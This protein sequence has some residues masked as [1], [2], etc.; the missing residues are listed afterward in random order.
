MGSE[1]TETLIELQQTQTKLIQTEKM[2][3]LGQ[4]VGG[5]SHE[6]NNPISFIYGNTE[7]AKE[8]ARDLLELVKL[9]QQHYPQPDTEIE[10]YIEEI[11]LDFLAADFLKILSSMKT[12]AERIRKIIESLRNFSR[13]DESEIKLVNI[14]EG[15]ENTL[16]IFN[17]RMNKIQLKK[18][19]G[20][21]SL[22]EC[23]PAHI[24]QV[25]LNIMTNAI[26][27]LN[28][29]LCEFQD[30]KLDFKPTLKIDTEQI[31]TNQIKISFWNNGP[32]IPPQ[33]IGKLF[34]PFFTTKT[35]GKGTGLGLTSCYQIMQ[36]HG[37][38]IEVTSNAEYGTEFAVILPVKMPK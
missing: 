7:Y 15:I 5:I 17:H 18:N 27:A 1:L 12:G 31:D 22:V 34:D 20:N 25:F 29:R 30:G 19:Y 11:D 4:M 13:L 32:V 24:N 3:S 23:Y 10:K 33:L 16:L 38:Q 35:V 14:N 37:G 6:I 2:S 36:Q 8:Y 28:E 21:V 9:Y 26:D